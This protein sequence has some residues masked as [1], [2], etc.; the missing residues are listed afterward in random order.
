[1]STLEV[2]KIN[3]EDPTMCLSTSGCRPRHTAALDCSLPCSN[4][5]SFYSTLMNR[6][7]G[8]MR[9]SCLKLRGILSPCNRPTKLLL[10]VLTLDL[11]CYVSVL[12]KTA[13]ESVLIASN[14]VRT[15][16]MPCVEAKDA[17]LVAELR[18]TCF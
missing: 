13:C 15:A 8:R 3:K 14:K 4:Y 1:M 12:M 2:D 10:G 9:I 6:I 5:R 16:I 17:Q 18:V 7:K 11:L